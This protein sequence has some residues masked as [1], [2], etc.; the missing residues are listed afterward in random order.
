MTVAKV[1]TDSYGNLGRKGTRKD[2]EFVA[3]DGV[4]LTTPDFT[5]TIANIALEATW[6]TGIKNGTVFPLTGMDGYEVQSSEDTIYESPAGLRKL[7]K[8]GKSRYMLRFDIPFD[9]HRTLMTYYNNADLTAWFLQDGK[10]LFYNDG[11]TAKGFSLSMLNIGRIADVPED[12]STPAFTPIYMDLED[13]RQKDVYGELI[14]P[15]WNVRDL[16]PL[17]DVVLEQVSASAT[18]VVIRVYAA[19]GYDSDGAANKVGIKGIA[20]T[21]GGDD[22]WSYSVSGSVSGITDN[23]DGTYT[24]AGSGIA[25]DDTIALKTPANMTESTFQDLRINGTNT[26][27]LVVT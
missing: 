15:S 14:E 1:T 4:I 13:Y 27:T 12:G 3:F 20:S 6:S 17:T 18:S 24:F 25:S 10:I 23:A 5:A 9:V 16:N 26:V 8:R 22:D 2:N 11:G 21:V 7:L 19:D